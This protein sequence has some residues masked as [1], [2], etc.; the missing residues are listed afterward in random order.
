MIFPLFRRGE[1]RDTISALYGAIVAQ[2]RLPGFYR[3][4]AVADTVE[5]R[6]ELIV[7]HLALVLDRLA[8]EPTLRELG[9][10]VFDLF[11]QDMDHNLR[12]MGVGDLTVPKEMRRMGDAFYGRAQAYR[13]AL[14]VG[15]GP[16]L[17][18]AIARNIY[19]GSP[20]AAAVAPRLA[21]YMCL[22]VG[23]TP[24]PRVPSVSPPASCAFRT[25]LRS[26]RPW[27]KLERD[28]KDRQPSGVPWSVPVAVED[29]PDAGL[30]IEIDAPPATRADIAALAAVLSLQKLSAVFDLTRRGTKVHV[31]GQ[32]TARVGQACVVTL[33]PIESEVSEAIDTTF[34]PPRAEMATD[35]EVKPDRE[36][37]EPLVDG[38]I[39][40]G[41]LA[42]EFLLI[43][44]D[45]YPR[46]AG[47]A[48]TPPKAEDVAARPFAVLA[49][50][51][52]PPG[53]AEP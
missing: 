22:A 46:K 9:Q 16:T 52:K 1:R 7:L 50:L 10:G 3:D 13:E 53:G 39:D 32:V 44:I 2:A 12:E 11:C 45:P 43:G 42:I 31:A 25:L 5:G 47:V 8:E 27:I 15:G 36:P 19:G 20:P 23:E 40:L 37:P 24:G 28:G 4:Y 29:I 26:L 17:A 48:F 14:A 33:E 30:H 35:V 49:A 51:K 6:F 41:A 38:K 18:D 34:A 21:A